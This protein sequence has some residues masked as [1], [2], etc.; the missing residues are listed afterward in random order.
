[1]RE[2]R[3]LQVSLPGRVRLEV[4][5][6]VF[7]NRKHARDEIVVVTFQKREHARDTHSTHGFQ[8]LH[9]ELILDQLRLNSTEEN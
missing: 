1:M 3:V 6:N 9:T 2:H 7:D 4:C 5:V 8:E